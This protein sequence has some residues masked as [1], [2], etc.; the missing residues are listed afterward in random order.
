MKTK[1][2]ILLATAPVL[3][4]GIT[5]PAPEPAPAAAAPWIKPTLDVRAFSRAL[6]NAKGDFPGS[7]T[8][9]WPGQSSRG[10]LAEV[11]SVQSCP[12]VSIACAKRFK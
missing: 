3:C 6:A 10:Q 5:E 4:A 1:A 12:D 8:I 7:V 2:A 9:H 11:K